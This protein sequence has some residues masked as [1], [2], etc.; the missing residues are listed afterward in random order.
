MRTWI[1]KKVAFEGLRTGF[2]AQVAF[3]VDQ[4]KNVPKIPLDAIRWADGQPYAAIP[5][6]DRAG[7][8]WR[9]IELGLVGSSDAEIKSGP[10]IGRPR[11]R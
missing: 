7:F 4:K 1:L 10:Q 9:S 2:S 11:D 5:R 6:A 8:D 3:F